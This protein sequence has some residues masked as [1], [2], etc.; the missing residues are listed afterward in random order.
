MNDTP[1]FDHHA[2]SYDDDL[3]HALAATG[4]DAEHF[5]RNRIAWLARCLR[6]LGYQPKLGIDYGCGTGSSTPLLLSI[7]GLS[8][9]VGV[10]VS[11]RIIARA[12]EEHGASNVRFA[13]V[14]EPLA[15]GAA[16]LAYC[17]GVFHHIDKPERPAATEY[18]YRSLRPGGLFAVWEN[19]PWNPAVH[20]VM[21]RCTFDEEAQMLS[22][23]EM[24]TLL[25]NSGFTIVRSDFLF[26]FPEFLKVFRLVEPWVSKL[27]FGGQY[28]VLARKKG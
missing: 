28:Q 11:P 17:N 19:N 5:A 22:V 25:R 24:K 8:E 27:P 14:A 15:P 3:N 2:E 7:L 26:I 20:Y 4:S 6:P 1:T 13:A 9:V 10:D 12:R 21:S 16:D 23:N 18:L